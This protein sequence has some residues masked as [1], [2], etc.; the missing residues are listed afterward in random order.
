MKRIIAAFGLLV[1]GAG[2][3]SAFETA[4]D[5][6]ATAITAVPFTITAPGNYYLPHDLTFTPPAGTAI[7]IEASQVILDLNGRTLKGT[8]KGFDTTNGIVIDNR[9]D[10]IIQNGDIDGFTFAGVLITDSAK[11][12]K[13]QKN[14]VLRVNFNNDEIGVLD[15]SGS[16]DVT[17]HCN[18]DGGSIGWYDISSLG[19]DRL[20]ACNFENQNANEGQNFGVAILSTPGNGVLVEDCL[21]SKGSNAFGEILQGATDTDRF[22]TFVGGAKRTGGRDNG[23][24]SN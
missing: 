13:N 4:Q 23:A 16:I 19:G 3:A 7:T 15:V 9:Q 24:I 17:E 11:K 2:F 20:Q 18:F 22:D 5:V 21:I 1:A 6:T 14:E 10:I 8:A 12:T